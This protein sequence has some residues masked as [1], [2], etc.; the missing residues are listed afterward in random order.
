MKS[1]DAQR[2]ENDH[3]DLDLHP[4]SCAS[5]VAPFRLYVRLYA[6]GRQLSLA[7]T[8]AHLPLRDLYLLHGT[9]VPGSDEYRSPG[10]AR[11]ILVS[12]GLLVCV[13]ELGVR[14]TV[15]YEY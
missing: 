8:D 1:T 15:L 14:V 4:D 5:N 2:L 7:P 6:T 13:L 3:D 10:E 11:A 9:G 12:F